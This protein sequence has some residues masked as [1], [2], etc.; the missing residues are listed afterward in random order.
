MKVISFLFR[1]ETYRDSSRR[2][3]KARKNQVMLLLLTV[4]MNPV[5]SIINQSAE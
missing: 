1:K 5:Q 2:G 4:E 3:I